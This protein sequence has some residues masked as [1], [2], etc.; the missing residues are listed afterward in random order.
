MAAQKYT[1]QWPDGSAVTAQEVYDAIM[2]GPVYFETNDYI[3]YSISN[4]YWADMEGAQEDSTNVAVVQVTT[5][6]DAYI[7]VGELPE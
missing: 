2:S 1:I 5:S 3:F 4:F 6:Y 7:V